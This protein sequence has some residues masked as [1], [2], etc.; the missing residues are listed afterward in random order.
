MTTAS[1][2]NEVSQV[3]AATGLRV[4]PDPFQRTRWER[5]LVDTWTD[6]LAGKIWIPG[7][8]RGCGCEVE[9]DI[10]Y[11]PLPK[12]I[13]DTGDE[14]Y[15]EAG[16]GGPYVRTTICPECDPVS[17]AYYDGETVSDTPRF[18]ATCP[19]G[20]Q[21]VIRNQ[22][23]SVDWKAAERVRSHN[24]FESGKGLICVGPSGTGKTT[25][26]WYLAQRL[27]KQD[28]AP[29]L[30]NA[31]DFARRAAKSA[32]N[33]EADKGLMRAKYL[34]IDDLGKEKITAT[35]ASA[36]WEVFDHRLSWNRWT[37]ITTRF[38]KGGFVDR[39]ADSDHLGQDIYRRIKDG[40]LPVEFTEQTGD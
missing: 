33:N 15:A 29:V 7:Y 9:G 21:E 36:M 24:F 2:T 11:L 26:M 20:V 10:A 1:E 34:L 23:P 31:I 16:Q 19:P 4:N 25:A 13:D 37:V 18:D 39:F 40:C 17:R 6:R 14:V 28:T 38:K 27:E 35:V 22:I 8:C 5:L 12:T 30:L 32:K 3:L